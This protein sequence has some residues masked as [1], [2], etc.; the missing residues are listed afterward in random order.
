M[1]IN[2]NLLL[3][4]LLFTGQLLSQDRDPNKTTTRERELEIL[5]HQINN[6]NNDYREPN[7]NVSQNSS[8]KSSNN[9][10]AK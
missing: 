9:K 8:N 2:T 7:R 3:A 1:K 5:V 10:S 4:M 6:N